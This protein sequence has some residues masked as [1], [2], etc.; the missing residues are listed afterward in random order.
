MVFKKYIQ[1]DYDIKA[2][3]GLLYAKR[4][5]ALK[6]TQF[7]YYTSKEQFILL[8]KPTCIIQNDKLL[9][10]KIVKRIKLMIANVL[11]ANG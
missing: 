6:K 11:I 10:A 5:C 3:G 8:Q 4:F 7:E 2:H 9:R 1:N